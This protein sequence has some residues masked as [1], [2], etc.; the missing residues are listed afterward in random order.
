MNLR[1]YQRNSVAATLEA[2][3]ENDSTLLVLPTGCG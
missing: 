3:K 2:W 1:D